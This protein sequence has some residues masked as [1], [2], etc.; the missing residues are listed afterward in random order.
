MSTNHMVSRMYVPSSQRVYTNHMVD[1]ECPE[2]NTELSHIVSGDNY[3]VWLQG[4]LINPHD[5]VAPGSKR[6]HTSHTFGKECPETN[7]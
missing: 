3:W 6:V 4:I 2:I 5:E 7:T 1:R